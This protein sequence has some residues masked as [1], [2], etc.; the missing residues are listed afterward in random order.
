AVSNAEETAFSEPAQLTVTSP[1]SF[2]GVL[3]LDGAGDYM[4]ISSSP[5]LQNATSFSLECW[6]YPRMSENAFASVI[7]KGDGLSGASARS[8]EL[9]WTADEMITASLFF[10]GLAGQPDFI[11]L[12]APVQSN[13]WTHV[14][15]T[16]DSS[17]GTARLLTNGV[18][19]VEWQ[20]PG[21]S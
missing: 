13:L 6:L 20:E 17:T 15:V 10:A 14:A 16:F 11:S 5:L 18:V 3:S 21:V 7:N 2:N 12:S 4:T 19:A 8:Y 9:R 1:D